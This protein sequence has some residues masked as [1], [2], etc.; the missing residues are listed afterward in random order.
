MNISLGLILALL[1][2][3]TQAYAE[4]D[5]VCSYMISFNLP[6]HHGSRTDSVVNN[7]DIC[8][9]NAF[10]PESNQI[11]SFT[12]RNYNAP[13]IASRDAMENEVKTILID[14]DIVSSSIVTVEYG[15]DQC[16]S[17]K[18]NG[19]DYMGRNWV[20]AFYW[21]DRY[22]DQTQKIWMGKGS[23]AIISNYPN[24]EDLLASVHIIRD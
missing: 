21:M 2:L 5:H 14:C 22:W 1:T 11:G 16:Y 8:R 6:V 18:G 20:V 3:I 10:T 12:I 23:C 7:P 4:S 15:V 9:V 24:S 13:Q 19:N 17:I